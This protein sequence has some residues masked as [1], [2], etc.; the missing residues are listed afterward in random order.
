MNIPDG[1]RIQFD[2]VMPIFRDK[3]LKAVSNAANIFYPVPMIELKNNGPDNII[4]TRAQPAAG[5][6][7]TL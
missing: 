2:D 1:F 4:Q 3:P 5:N 6:Q 7:C